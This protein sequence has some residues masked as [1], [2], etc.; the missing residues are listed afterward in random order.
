MF[1]LNISKPLWQCLGMLMAANF[2]KHQSLRIFWVNPQT[3][4]TE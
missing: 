1:I 4:Q 2:P 3:P